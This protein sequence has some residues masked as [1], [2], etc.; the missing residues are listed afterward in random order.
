[1]KNISI[2]GIILG[3]FL[4]VN[5]GFAEEK[6]LSKE[7]VIALFSD[8]TFDGV[9]VIK[10]KEFRIYSSSNGEFEIEYSSGKT[11]SRYWRVNADGEHCVSKKEGK[12]GR[13][14]VVISVGDG[15]YHKITNDEHTHTLNNFVSGNQL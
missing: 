13:C 15:V 8:K 12:G 11:K 9:Q 2:Y 3:V 1:M 10:D 5:V 4:G 6:P 7:E 14:S